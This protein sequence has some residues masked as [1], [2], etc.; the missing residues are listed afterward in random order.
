MDTILAKSKTLHPS[1]VLLNPLN[2]FP[3]GHLLVPFQDANFPFLAK[4]N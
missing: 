3:S 2:I 4:K 1:V